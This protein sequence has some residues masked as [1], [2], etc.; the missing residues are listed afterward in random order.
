MLVLVTGLTSCRHTSQN[1]DPTPSLEQKGLLD[2]I[3]YYDSKA[4]SYRLRNNPLSKSYASRALNVA[5]RL[6]TKEGFVIAYAAKAHSF[7]QDQQDSAFLFYS[8]ALNLVGQTDVHLHQ[9]L[10]SILYNTAVLYSVAENYKQALIL[11]DSSINLSKSFS[12]YS[13]CALALNEKGGMF[14]YLNDLPKARNYYDSALKIAQGH[15]LYKETGIILGNLAKM[16]EDPQKIISLSKQAIEIIRKSASPDDGLA[17]LLI[18]I[19]TAQSNPD[20]ALLYLMEWLKIAQ[21]G[22]L[23]Q[24]QIAAWNSMAYS[25]LDKGLIGQAEYCLLK[26][27]IPLADSVKNMDWLA[28]LYDSYTDV[29]CAK[30]E[31][32]MAVSFQKRATETRALSEKQKSSGQVHLLDAMLN[33]K[34]KDL[35]LSRKDQELSHQR[36]H[37]RFLQLTLSVGTLLILIILF[38]FIWY[39]MRNRLKLQGERIGAARK[40]IETEEKEKRKIAMELHDMAGHF[41]MEMLGQVEKAESIGDKPGDGIKKIVDELS[42]SVRSLSHW[43]SSTMID[44]YDLPELINNLCYDVR[45]F[46]GLQVELILPK[47]NP[48]LS[49]EIK[50][51]GFRIIQELLNN[52]IRHAHSAR[53]NIGISYRENNLIFEYRDD[54]PGFDPM[55]ARK[56]GMGLLNIFER[57]K[58]LG[59]Q[60][61]LDT[62]PG[63]GV[64]W[65]ISIPVTRANGNEKQDLEIT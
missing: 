25:Y 50:V 15:S 2:S 36:N 60:A 39:Q 62:T 22:N 19:G 13:E 57:S 51:H 30:K 18:N 43:L 54:G 24:E 64:H 41:S 40:I 31:F 37:E 45:K 42:E 53:I 65:E 49:L 27:G 8:S 3:K 59:G 28:T 61:K 17:G 48:S 29:L 5:Q 21:A 9:Y 34:N 35:L 63:Y 47:Y 38:L 46:N 52:A 33:V 12:C 16:E 44:K 14:F 7:L 1:A 58:L 32:K 11:L 23:Y 6:N 26:K 10:P 55:Q 4:V 56:Q 20:S